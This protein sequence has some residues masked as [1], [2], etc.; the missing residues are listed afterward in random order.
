MLLN[1][2]EN[3]YLFILMKHIYVDG[4]FEIATELSGH[5][6]TRL[7]IDPLTIADNFDR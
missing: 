4:R 1:N 2:N 6:T 5:V 3:G 7:I